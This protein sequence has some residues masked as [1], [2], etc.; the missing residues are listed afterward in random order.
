[1]FREC[2]LQDLLHPGVCEVLVRG[3]VDPIRHHRLCRKACAEKLELLLCGLLG[4][5][6]VVPNDPAP[7]ACLHA[8]SGGDDGKHGRKMIFETVS[9]EGGKRPCGSRDHL[10]ARGYCHVVDGVLDPI[11]LISGLVGTL[12]G[13]ALVAEAWD[14]LAVGGA[15]LRN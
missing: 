14:D 4:R 5:P 1:M 6:T 12:V 10:N 3:R 7:S 13:G 8:G 9:V 11:L 15:H 2:G